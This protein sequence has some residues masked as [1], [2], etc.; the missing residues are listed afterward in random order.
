MLSH[1]CPWQAISTILS[2]YCGILLVSQCSYHPLSLCPS[3]AHY[4]WLNVFCS[5]TDLLSG[6]KFI[7]DVWHCSSAFVLNPYIWFITASR[8]KPFTG[9]NLFFENTYVILHYITNYCFCSM[10]CGQN[11]HLWKWV[12]QI[13]TK[14]QLHFRLFQI[15]CCVSGVLLLFFYF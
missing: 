6:T 5:G 2:S 14:L 13:R 15:H 12:K 1:C 10:V 11:L 8:C 3:L 4:L 7:T 9:L